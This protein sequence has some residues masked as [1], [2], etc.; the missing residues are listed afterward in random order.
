[1]AGFTLIEVLVVVAI[2]ALLIAILVPALSRVRVHA[3]IATCRAS[4]A[5]MCPRIRVAGE[6]AL[7]RSRCRRT[8][9]ASD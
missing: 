9:S 2:I 8:L 6:V 1:M 5:R 3:M 7:W 4:F